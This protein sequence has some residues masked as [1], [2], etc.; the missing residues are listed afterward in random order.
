MRSFVFVSFFFRINMVSPSKHLVD[1]TQP[2]QASALNH[3]TLPPL[4]VFPGPKPR[5]PPQILSFNEISSFDGLAGLNHLRHLDLG[6]NIIEGVQRYHG[7]AGPQATDS[8]G[9]DGGD[10]VAANDDRGG[11]IACNLPP[12][13]ME[14]TRSEVSKEAPGLGVVPGAAPATAVARPEGGGESGRSEERMGKECASPAT[15]GIAL[16]CLTRLDLNNNIL[17]NLDDL[18]AREE[19]K[20]TL[21]TKIL[22][23][24][25]RHTQQYTMVFVPYSL[26]GVFHTLSSTWT[27]VLSPANLRFINNAEKCCF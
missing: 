26:A 6:Y 16:P 13:R 23:H 12:G 2:D 4:A 19:M 9:G 24:F 21:N 20:M 15:A 11:I 22:A 5:A 27:D 14:H 1:P 18:K 7:A 8:A 3:C 17:H 10:S 25:E